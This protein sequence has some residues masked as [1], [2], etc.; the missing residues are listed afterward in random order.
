[1]GRDKP[2]KTTIKTLTMTLTLGVVIMSCS[3]EKDALFNRW[4]H[5]TTAHYN[6]YFNAVELIKTSL[7]AYDESYQEDYTRILPIYVIP[8]EENKSA[9][10]P[11]MNEAITKVSRVISRHSMPS[12]EDA[13]NKDEEWNK[14]IDENW[15]VMGQSYYYI[16]DYEEA[17]MRFDYILG[18]FQGDGTAMWAKLW[19]AKCFIEQGKYDRALTLFKELEQESELWPKKFEADYYTVQA[20]MLLQ[21]QQ[22]QEAADMIMEALD[23]TKKKQMRARLTFILA[24]IYEHL[25]DGQRA[26]H[27]YAQVEKLKPEYEMMFYAKIFKALAFTGG[28]SE[29][30][31]K[32]LNKMIADDKNIEYRDQIY[33]ALADI[34]FKEGDEPLGIEYLQ[35]SAASSVNNTRQKAASYLRLADLYFD[36]KDYVVAQAYYDSTSS[37]LDPEYPDYAEIANKTTS[38]GDLV[39]HLNT[40][41]EQD[42]L[43]K[44]A[45]MD[46]ADVVKLIEGMIQ[47]VIDGREARAQAQ[48]D[49]MLANMDNNQNN[50]NNSGSTWYFYNQQSLGYGFSEFK[51]NFGDRPLED[52]WRRKNK[53]TSPG[54]FDETTE[55]VDSTGAVAADDSLDVMFYYQHIPFGD[56]AILAS[57]DLILNA[58]YD[59]GVIYR[60]KL[61]DNNEASKTF[62]DLVTRYDARKESVTAHYQLYRIYT[63]EGNDSKAEY[64][65]EQILTRFP[66]S[67]P[68]IRILNPNLAE[69]EEK[70]RQEDEELYNDI[71]TDYL[72]RQYNSV[73]L[74]CN[75]VITE[76]P[77]NYYIDRYYFLKA[78][79][80]SALEPGTNT[81]NFEK[82]LADV[83]EKFPDLETGKR[84]EFILNNIRNA[85]SVTDVIEGSGNYIYASGSKHVFVAIFPNSAGSIN[86]LKIEFSDF[87]TKYFPHEG[88]KT[89]SYFL[90]GDNQLVKV[91]SFED[92]ATAM[93][94]YNAITNN[95][96]DINTVHEKELQYFVITESN[97]TFFFSDKNT[98]EYME[99]F[100]Q[101]YLNE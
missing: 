82:A 2:Y 94:Y 95:V 99:F 32:E 79:V 59:A 86:K 25:G 18:M 41:A 14:W 28:S 84:A 87:H 42:S 37:Y 93:D 54:T 61:L 53:N 5:G 51:K 68:A 24:Q 16:R 33:Y 27:F 67:E 90:D 70:K 58:L 73:L 55:G 3:T 26:M 6:G 9:M 92:M 36:K 72:H 63:E 57:H 40:V 97:F 69:D 22:Y 31:K 21:R 49:M 66:D 47:N 52:D 60:D 91:N 4:F 96:A 85:Q 8:G 44:L 62:D 30:L 23:H 83:V 38:L 11:E 75:D 13:R 76:D 88:L 46:S 19:K 100:N 101:K 1:M 45:A 71:Y 43:L 64:H 12:A 10:A 77:L 7:D 15:L 89:E 74:A 20:D 29:D 35:L 34:A 48:Q 50:Q 80:I 39:R 56:S 81:T 78:M 17:I 98:A 65:K